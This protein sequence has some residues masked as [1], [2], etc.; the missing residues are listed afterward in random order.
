[1]FVTMTI[2]AGGKFYQTHSNPIWLGSKQ[3]KTHMG[4][5]WKWASMENDWRY[6][7]VF[8]FAKNKLVIISSSSSVV[9]FFYYCLAC[10]NLEF[11][12]RF[13]VAITE[14]SWKAIA[15]RRLRR[16]ELVK[17]LGKGAARGGAAAVPVTTPFWSPFWNKPTTGVE[18]DMTIW[19]LPSLSSSFPGPLWHSVTPPLWEILA[20]PLVN[21]LSGFQLSIVK[22]K[23]K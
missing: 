22:P 15:S 18:N 13:P 19:W 23:S 2:G 17:V 14:L 7:T 1:M 16:L 8:F 10:E 3:S 21:D 12:F 5:A 4:S 9:F 6:N 11:R 20:V